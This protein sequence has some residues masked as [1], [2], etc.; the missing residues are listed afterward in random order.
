MPRSTQH[1]VPTISPAKIGDLQATKPLWLRFAS[2]AANLSVAREAVEHLAEVGGMDQT[3]AG[4]VGL[5]VNE[6]LANVMRHAYAGAT[7]R[8][9]ELHASWWHDEL[10]ITIRDWGSGENPE[11]RPEK[12]RDPLKPGGLGLICLRKLMHETTFSPQ[13]DG[14]LLTMKRRR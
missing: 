8:P 11:A 5:C 12:Q 10:T 6:A 9:I 4:E 13:P 14:M 3:A 1:P 2:D 7:D